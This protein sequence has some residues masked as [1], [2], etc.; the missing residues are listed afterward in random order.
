MQPDPSKIQALQDLPTPDSQ[1]KLQSFLGLVNYLQPFIHGLTTKTTFL[2]EQLAK[3]DWNPLTDP[4][5]QHIKAWICQTPLNA[6]LTYYDRSNPIIVQMNAS[7]YRLGAAIIQ[8]SHPIAFSS[9]TLTDVE[10]RFANI[11]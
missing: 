9:K 1:L 11:K 4:A 3:W 2:H 6:T 5:F 8:S 7:K 10:T